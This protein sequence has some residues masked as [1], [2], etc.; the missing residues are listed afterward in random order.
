MKKRVLTGSVILIAVVLFFLSRMLTPYIFDCFI[1][2]CGI[3]A[4]IEIAQIQN[5]A[6]K[7]VNVALV[8]TM[9]ITIL[10]GTI[11]G[12]LNKRGFAYYLVYV[13]C[14]IIFYFILAFIFA[15]ITKK[16]SLK[17]LH[18]S[19]KTYGLAKYSVIKALR[20]VFLFIYPSFFFAS[21]YFINHFAEFS[22]IV[23]KY[24]TGTTD[25]PAINVSLF[26]TFILIFVFVCTMLTDTF[27]MLSG[28]L[29]KGKKL[30][31]KISPKKT[32][33]GAI[34]GLVMA[35]IGTLCLF[36]IFDTNP[37]FSAV[38]EKINFSAFK[39]ILL[40]LF[41]SVVSQCGDIFES[42]LK[43]KADVK[44]SG[45]ILPGH[46]GIM[47]RMDGICF[48]ALYSFIFISLLFI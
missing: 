37:D 22:D 5:K 12:I 29:F 34:G 3:V 42:F 27:A 35:I 6:G 30:C 39:V 1:A 8:C 10:V 20:T 21:F 38:Y 14:L 24:G 13:L 16:D 4:C 26:A 48:N 44:D 18:M 25:N 23:S 9:P 28:M 47:D 46:G 32:I 36:L 40:A 45:N 33:S 11:I 19:R 31:T 17:E 7:N 43:R 2:L 15:L 41:G